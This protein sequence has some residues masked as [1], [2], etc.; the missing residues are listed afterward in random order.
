MGLKAVTVTALKARG[1]YGDGDGLYLQISAGGHK[2]WILRYQIDKKRREMGLG[3]LADVSLAEA[4]RKAAEARQH[5]AEG[6]DPIKAR[7]NARDAQRLAEAQA[8]TFKQAAEQYI[9]GHEATWK[10]AKHRWQ[11]RKSLEDYVYPII[12]GM[13]VGDIGVADVRRVLEP[14]WP[15]MPETASRIRGRV[16]TVI[17]AA[18]A[19]DESR[20]SNPARWERHKHVFPAKS[21]VRKVQ[22]LAALPYAELPSFMA[23][24]RKLDSASAPALEFTI[25]TA[26]RSGEA[27]G[28]RWPEIDREAK[29]WTVPASRMKAD[30]AH[31]VP[32]S[33]AALAIVE[34]MAEVRLSSYV[35]PGWH[36]GQP[37][38]GMA[39]LMCLRRL[40]PAYTVH[41]FRSSFSDWCAERTSFPHIVAEAALAHV[42]ANKTEA[43][44]RRGELL[45]K[46][47]QLMEA[48]ADFC[49]GG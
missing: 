43:A 42:V 11:W 17:N 21:K 37:L 48:W 49:S 18:R 28:L 16:E 10:N 13:A 31:R 24:L 33:D 40:R 15:K 41:G 36:N 23:E 47:R 32:L 20:W 38:S 9:A 4:R 1:T 7:E 46:R 2:S 26:A 44:Y 39:L 14:I 12:G 29:L 3:G 25:L 27:T 19:D 35:F 6:V 30:K 22:H 8:V 34:K 45:E 5:L